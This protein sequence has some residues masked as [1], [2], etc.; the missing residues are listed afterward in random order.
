[1]SYGQQLGDLYGFNYNVD[2]ARRGYKHSRLKP[3]FIHICTQKTPAKM[4][5]QKAV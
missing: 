4:N 5:K 3:I 1:M 2:T